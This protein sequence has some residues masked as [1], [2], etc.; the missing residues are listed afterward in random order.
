LRAH[1]IAGVA[2]AGLP[3]LAGAQAPD[4]DIQAMTRRQLE[5]ERKVQ[6]QAVRIDQLEQLLRSRLGEPVAPPSPIPAPQAPLPANSPDLADSPGEAAG[7]AA[8]ARAAAESGQERATPE[9]IGPEHIPNLG[10]KIYESDRAQVYMRLFSYARY[11]N[12]KGL[13]PTYTDYFGN[14]KTVSRREDFQLNKFFLPFS[15]WFLDERFRF[16]L[17][18]WSSNTAQGEGAQTVGAGNLSFIANSHLT[19]GAGI[20]ALPTVRSTEGQHPYWLGVDARMTAD[21]FF[22]GSYTSGVWLKG[23]VLPGMNYMAMLANNLST[24]G[25]S[26]SQLGNTLDT[27]SVMWNWMPTTQEFG[28]LGAFGDFEGHQELA[29]RIGVHFTHSTEDR[30]SQPGT[31]DIDNTQIRLTD[32][33]IVFT[34]D[35]FGPGI[36]VDQVNYQM[37][38]I[39]AGLKYKGFSLEGEYYWRALSKFRGPGVGV[40]AGVIGDIHDDGYQLQASA[41]LLPKLLQL[42]VGS[43]GIFGHYGDGSEFRAGFNYFPMRQRGLR[44]NGEWLNLNDSPVGYTAVPYPVGGNGNIYHVNFE[45]SF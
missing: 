41:M 11:L 33:S 15:G 45:L 23:E 31:E 9:N 14:V 22:R 6:E 18:V 40:G 44:V 20:A 43:A 16:Y 35:L 32:G 38:S 1:P 29:T 25:I 21:E 7:G 42:Y 26:A 37:A 3:L 2:L 39:D 5:L 30:Q 34:R 4:I 17:Y 27:W 28:P 8:S 24:L 36:T 10:F 19:I 13:D 12:Q